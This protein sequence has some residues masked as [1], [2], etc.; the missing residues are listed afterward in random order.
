MKSRIN[1]FVIESESPGSTTSVRSIFGSVQN[2]LMHAGCLG[3]IAFYDA[4]R[5]ADLDAAA[6]AFRAWTMTLPL[7]EPIVLWIS[8]HG[9]DPEPGVADNIRRLVGTSGVSA[10]GEEVSW[11][12]LFDPVKLAKNPKRVVMLMDVCWGSSPTAPSRLSSPRAN[13]PALLFGPARPACR[14]ELDVAT[15]SLFYHLSKSGIP[16]Q[17]TSRNLVDS[18]N[19]HFSPAL[20]TGTPFY[21]VWWWENDRLHRHPEPPRHV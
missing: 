5:K 17:N 6:N 7:D 13:R 9:A 15:K 8:I 2:S 20:A 12:E 16:D 21:R 19:T 4:P 18:L 14:A 11:L 3:K 1:V 10:K